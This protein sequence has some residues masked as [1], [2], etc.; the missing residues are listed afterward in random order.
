MVPSAF[1]VMAT[2]PLTPSGRLIAERFLHQTE[3]GLI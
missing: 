1:V 3:P 2:L